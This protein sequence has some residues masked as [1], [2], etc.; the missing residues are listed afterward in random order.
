MPLVPLLGVLLWRQRAAPAVWL[1]IAAA[2][3]GLYLLTGAQPLALNHGDGLTLICAV[4]FALHILVTGRYAGRL[5][6]L[7]LSL[8]QLLAVAAYSA[9]PQGLL[10]ESTRFGDGDWGAALWHPAVLAG[11]LVAG[12]L[13]SAFATWAQTASQRLLPAHKVALVFAA[14]PVIAHL[15]AWLVLGETLGPAGL[16]GAVL[17]LVGMLVAELGD[18]P[19]PLQLKPL[20][21]RVAAE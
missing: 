10:G 19:R 21:Q 8:V 15:S 3:A 20:D 6:I 9:L 5:P 18:R 1:G 16:T 12:L 2:T 11:V 14:E 17:I 13:G 7:A 4:A